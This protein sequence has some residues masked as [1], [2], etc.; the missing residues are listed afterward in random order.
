LRLFETTPASSFADAHYLGNG[1]LGLTVPGGVPLEC[2]TVNH[3]TLWS[4]SETFRENPEHLESLRKCQA[5]VLRGDVKEANDIINEHMDGR[6]METF[7]PLARI[8]LMQGQESN[9]RTMPLKQCIEPAPGDITA[10]S[11]TLS[12]SDATETVLWS[13]DGQSF[14]R[15]AFVSH[16]DDVAIVQLTCDA[17]ALS[18]ALSMDSP[19]RFTGNVTSREVFLTG[20]APDH[21][22][23]SYTSVKPGLVYH[24]ESTSRALRFA[25]LARLLSTD[26]EVH[27]D[28]QRLYVRHATY[29]VIAIKAGTNYAGF[30]E[31]RDP[32]PDHVLSRLRK[33]LDRL[34][35]LPYEVLYERHLA[36]YAAL[37]QRVHL[38]LEPSLTAHLPTSERLQAMSRGMDDP[39]LAALLVQY[40]RYLTISASRP[41]SQ[42]MHLQGLWNDTVMP[43]WSSNYTTNINV[44]MNYWP[45]ESLALPECHLPL[46]Q[47]LEELSVAGQQTARAYY[48]CQGWVCHHNT[49]LWRASEPSCEDAS[50]AWWPMGGAWMAGH[51]A[52]HDRYTLDTA[53]LERML[54]TL[55]GAVAF[56]LDFLIEGPDGYLVTAPS[57]SPENKYLYRG[58]VDRVR[59]LAEEVAGESRCSPTD[60]D[61]TAVTMACTMDMSLLRE[62]FA[63]YLEACQR[64]GNEDQ[65]AAAARKALKRFPPYRVG[66]LGTLLEWYEDFEECSPGMSHISHMYPVY[67]AQLITEKTPELF[68]A[69]QRALERRALHASH[70]GGWPA[71]WRIALF[72]RFHN[73]LECTHLLKSTLS[74]LAC[75]LMTRS[76]QQIDAIFGLGAGISEMLLQSHQGYIELLPA[77]PVDWSEGKVTGLRAQGNFTV[78]ISWKDGWITEGTIT[79]LSGGKLSVKA[80]GLLGCDSALAEEDFLSLDTK[81]GE[82]ISLRFAPNPISGKE[83][84]L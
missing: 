55:R 27:G 24:E 68:A 84:P 76:N 45:C 18:F 80:R 23:P 22:E 9:R 32:D 61:I 5:A 19:L 26:G 34:E 83:Y 11:R 52:I 29:A 39:S 71:A 44:E 38:S 70:P 36:D 46:L 21:A 48:D 31:V 1:S 3:D 59:S 25:C 58:G 50:W 78:D 67:P 51:I 40:V 69:A 16:P 35:G 60:R 57:I 6:W 62:L 15:K 73:P 43:P 64:T 7:L 65:T 4:G 72:A 37:F 56:Y 74:G 12:L 47:M 53:C 13:R 2:L 33:A 42:P 82:S 28:D 79:S 41:G 75:G 54:P 81:T 66:H 8:Y 49:D 77:I 30:N 10:Y 17:P 63:T 14:V 20:R